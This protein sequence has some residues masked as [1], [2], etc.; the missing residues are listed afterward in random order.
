MTLGRPLAVVTVILLAASLAGAADLLA[1]DAV[2]PPPPPKNEEVEEHI[3]PP[4]PPPGVDRRVLMVRTENGG[5]P[6]V[7]WIGAKGAFL[8][9]H[10]TELTPELRRHF[11]VPEE[12]GVM[13][14]RVVED[15]PAMS[16]GLQ[17]GDIVTAVDGE[18]VEGAW[19]LQ[20]SIVQKEAGDV[21][22]LEIWRDGNVQTIEATLDERERPKLE[23]GRM[24]MLMPHIE[25]LEDL[26]EL[27]REKMRKALKEARQ[28]MQE[29]GYQ[30]S[31]P[32]DE[33]TLEKMMT[34][35]EEALADS[36]LQEKLR[37][38]LLEDQERRERQIEQKM[39]E[40]EKKLQELERKLQSESN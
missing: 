21:V 1:G 30:L 39:R 40:L 32:F 12:A 4:P 14:G 10:L 24:E 31:V 8:G 7:K 23:V 15:T 5:K 9:V 3:A 20:R 16:A 29:K 33:Q 38:Q 2:P 34:Q 35:L 27:D 6:F 37:E 25:N 19:D 36:Q 17:V 18:P 11:G 28:S 22:Q 26:P 13:I